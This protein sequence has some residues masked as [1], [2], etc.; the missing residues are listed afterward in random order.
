MNNTNN[1]NNNKTI[2]FLF[3]HLV[4]YPQELLLHLLTAKLRNCAHVQ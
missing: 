3:C 2:L 1:N 4:L